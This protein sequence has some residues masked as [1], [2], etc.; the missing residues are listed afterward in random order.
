[1]SAQAG[2]RGAGASPAPSVPEH[3]HEISGITMQNLDDDT[4]VQSAGDSPAKS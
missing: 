4:I 3:L 1:M 2:G